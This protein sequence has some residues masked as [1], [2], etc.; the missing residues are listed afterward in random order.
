MGKGN[1][2]NSLSKEELKALQGDVLFSPEELKELY[3]GFIKEHPSGTMDFDSW[4]V[5]E[6]NPV[7][8][9]E[10]LSRRWFDI[11][12]KDKSGK[13]DFKELATLLS[14]LVRGSPEDR[15]SVVFSFYDVNGD[16]SLTREELRSVI[17][18]IFLAAKAAGNEFLMDVDT[19]DDFVES[20]FELV[21]ANKDGEVS[22]DEF[23]SIAKNSK[24]PIVDFL[25]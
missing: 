16:G 2:K 23:V 19:V 7:M 12:D 10:A 24:Y 18:S 21:D 13:V 3:K 11:Y 14:A 1:S 25:L 17:E 9:D 4:L 15:L 5:S 6:A 22:L 8:G 20:F